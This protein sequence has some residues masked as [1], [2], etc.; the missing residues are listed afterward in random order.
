MTEEILE[1]CDSEYLQGRDLE[2]VSHAVSR[3]QL[4][5][6]SCQEIFNAPCSVTW[7]YFCDEDC[8]VGYGEQFLLPRQLSKLTNY[9]LPE[10]LPKYLPVS[11]VAERQ[12]NIHRKGYLVRMDSEAQAVQQMSDDESLHEESAAV[13]G[14]AWGLTIIFGLLVM[15]FVLK[16]FVS[17]IR[18]WHRD[19]KHQPL[20]DDKS[21]DLFICG[22]AGDMSLLNQLQKDLANFGYSVE[23]TSESLFQNNQLCD[24]FTHKA[25]D[26][27]S[28]IYVFS[29][30]TI[31]KIDKNSENAIALH[32]EWFS[33]W[34]DDGLKQI[35]VVCTQNGIKSIIITLYNNLEGHK[36]NPT[37]T[38][39][40]IKDKIEAG[41]ESIEHDCPVIEF[42]R[43]YEEVLQLKAAQ[44]NSNPLGLYD[45]DPEYRKSLDKLR[46]AL[47]PPTSTTVNLKSEKT[48]DGQE[49]N[50]LIPDKPPK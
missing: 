4:L 36:A 20:D 1:K 37:P 38:E 14:I 11:C 22:A 5:E 43:K 21:L 48:K 16:K 12:G 23:V 46:L 49:L 33:S 7:N 27:R 50:K 17:V 47:H 28:L 15:M 10:N 8:T 31:R 19:R 25:A 26:V 29:A 34:F 45:I 32:H 41:I 30:N 35:Q 9:E 44:P 39:Q 40:K 24:E 2:T 13:K 3:F 18:L 6:C 42:S